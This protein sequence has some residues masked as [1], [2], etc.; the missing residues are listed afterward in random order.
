[1]NNGADDQRRRTRATWKSDLKNLLSFFLSIYYVVLCCVVFFLVFVLVR[2]ITKREPL[3][4]LS[5]LLFS[6][7]SS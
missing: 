4:L 2:A 6:F 7:V 3:C 1:M 5:L